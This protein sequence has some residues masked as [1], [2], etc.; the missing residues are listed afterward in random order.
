MLAVHVTGRKPHEL[1]V[2]LRYVHMCIN[3]PRPIYIP[4]H[5]AHVYSMCTYMFQKLLMF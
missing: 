2:M 4:S 3:N 5:N 1:L